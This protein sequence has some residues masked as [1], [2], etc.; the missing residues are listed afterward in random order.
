MNAG[1]LLKVVKDIVALLED[2]GVLLPDGTFDKSKLDTLQED[3]AFAARVEGVLAK[4]GLDV[5]D[6]VN[7]V[8]AILPLIAELID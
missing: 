5:P 8:I 2:S 7:K 3:I 4:Y 1:Q 6:K